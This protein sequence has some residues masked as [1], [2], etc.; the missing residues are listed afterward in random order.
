MRLAAFLLASLWLAGLTAS[1]QHLPRTPDDHPDFQGVWSTMGLT[2]MERIPAATATIVDDAE[3]KTLTAAIYNQL[4]SKEFDL[5][6]D[7]NAFNADVDH[8]L[9]VNG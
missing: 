5:A 6:S 1:A 8:L 3:A 9:R 7:P 2:P 4:R